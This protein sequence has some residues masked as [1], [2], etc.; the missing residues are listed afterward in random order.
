MLLL[1]KNGRSE[2]QKSFSCEKNHFL[3]YGQVK[4]MYLGHI[5]KNEPKTN[6]Q[7]NHHLLLQTKKTESDFFHNKTIFDLMDLSEKYRL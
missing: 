4:K 5:G 2:N 3:F 1:T 7:Q 6:Y